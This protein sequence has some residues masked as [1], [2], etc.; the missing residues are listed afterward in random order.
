L[1]GRLISEKALR[2]LFSGNALGRLF[3]GHA[4]VVKNTVARTARLYPGQTSAGKTGKPAF[5]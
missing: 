5:R 1:S 3:S 4:A 2:R